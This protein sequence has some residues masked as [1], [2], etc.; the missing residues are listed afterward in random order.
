VRATVR[1]G[2]LTLDGTVDWNFERRAAARAVEYIAGVRN[3][4]NNIELKHVT[5]AHDV[6]ERIATA[7]RRA[8]DLD[9]S[10]VHVSSNGGHVTL[11]GS[12]SSWAERERAQRT[13][14][15]APGVTLVS[16]DLLIR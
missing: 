2:M 11:T 14:W 13:A 10:N 16:D 8:A 6:H 12:V 5:S 3:V 15:S 9:A 4:S 1:D 7:M